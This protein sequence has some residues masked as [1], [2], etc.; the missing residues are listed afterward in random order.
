MG[1]N[2]DNALTLDDEACIDSFDSRNGQYSVINSGQNATVTTNSTIANKM[3]INGGGCIEGDVFVGPG[4]DPNVVISNT[5]AVTGTTGDQSVEY[6][7]PTLAE[8]TNVGANVGNLVYTGVSTINTNLHA[9]NLTIDNGGTLQIDGYIT[10]L[11]EN[12]FQV[13]S[14]S[15]LEIAP[16]GSLA[17]YVKGQFRLDSG[18][19]MV[20]PKDPRVLTVYVLGTQNAVLASGSQMYGVMVAPTARLV[21]ESASEFYGKFVGDGMEAVS[22]S[23]FHQDVN[24]DVGAVVQ[25]A[26]SFNVRWCEQP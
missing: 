25:G 16:G 8:P 13:N 7:M 11:V 21:L 24:P 3:L 14:G 19:H 12:D 22:A 20:D 17:L 5:S 2:V 4:G 18:G 6:P 9:Q 26:D 1:L 23:E 10:I 15:H